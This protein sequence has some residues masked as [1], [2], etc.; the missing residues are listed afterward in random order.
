MYW[1]GDVMSVIG[2]LI[3]Q[4]FSINFVFFGYSVTFGN[5]F[6]FTWIS[7]LLIGFIR[8]LFD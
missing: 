7:V 5:V 4:L 8:R 1:E 2:D 6:Y 3:K